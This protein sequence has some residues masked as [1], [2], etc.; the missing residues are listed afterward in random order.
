M[1]TEELKYLF[2]D[3]AFI[4][5]IEGIKKGVVPAEKVSDGPLIE[6][7]QPWEKQW[8][9]SGYTNVI[10]D[11]EEKIYKMW[12]MVNEDA[13]RQKTEQ[14]IADRLQE[15]ELAISKSTSA[16][17]NA[18]NRKCLPPLFPYRMPLPLPPCL[19]TR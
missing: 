11:E 8:R 7:D 5:S 2:I 12:W 9:M 4:E 17:L 18:A 16:P 13:E 15:E 3:D 10:Y 14:Y 1:S 19:S 6:N